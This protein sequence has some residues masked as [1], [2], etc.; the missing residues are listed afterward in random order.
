MRHIITP[1]ALLHARP[2]DRSRSPIMLNIH[3]WLLILC[4][5]DTCQIQLFY[6]PRVAGETMAAETSHRQ[7][8]HIAAPCR[9]PDAET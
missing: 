1:I 6:T 9:P 8:A 7:P 5:K 4:S 3:T 2:Q